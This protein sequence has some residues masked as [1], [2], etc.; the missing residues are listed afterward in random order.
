MRKI[1]YHLHVG[2]A[3][4]DGTRLVVFDDNPTNKELDGI[5]Y[6]L[7]L[8][9]ADMYGYYPP[10]DDTD[11][12]DEYVSEGIEGSWEEYDVNKHGELEE[13]HI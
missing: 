8:D 1:V 5:G 10:S 3:G 11:E 2:F 6:E 13:T 12:Y 9:W 4:M 7:A